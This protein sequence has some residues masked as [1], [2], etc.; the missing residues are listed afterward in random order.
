[1]TSFVLKVPYLLI[2][3]HTIA[4]LGMNELKLPE[5]TLVTHLCQTVQ[6]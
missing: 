3:V 2:F 4:Y 6:I 1:M 5:R